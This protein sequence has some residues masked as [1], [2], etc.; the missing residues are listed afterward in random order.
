[1]N[2]KKLPQLSDLHKSP[3]DAFKEDQLNALLNQHPNEAWVKQHP[4]A[5]VKNDKGETV[6]AKYIPVDKIE[7]M[8]TYIFQR[9]KLEVVREGVMLNSVYATVRLH[10]LNPLTGEWMFHDGVGAAPC[11]LD[12]QS[13]ASDL[14]A[15][16]SSAIQMA[17]PAAV[18]YALKDAA[19]H[20]GAL[21]GRDLN[22]KE[23][24]NFAGAYMNESQP[25]QPQPE[26]QK[27]MTPNFI[28]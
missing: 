16:K 7:F 17:L 10:V 28:L 5:T 21:F 23:N 18:S 8:L 20:F 3:K 24:L 14:S 9:W 13:R 15:I 1:M 6:K 12:A 11:Q 4:T 19:E 27:P 25:E 26:Q 2:E 22:R